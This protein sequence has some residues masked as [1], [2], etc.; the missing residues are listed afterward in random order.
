MRTWLSKKF[1]RCVKSVK[2]SVRTR[3]NSNKES[4]AIAICTTSVLHPRGRT[5]KKYSRKRLVTQKKKPRG[6]AAT[7][8][9]DDT[10][11]WSKYWE[12]LRSLSGRNDITLDVRRIAQEIES[13]VD[14]TYSV[15]YRTDVDNIFIFAIRKDSRELIHALYA[16][17]YSKEQMLFNIDILMRT[18][19]TSARQASAIAALSS[20]RGFVANLS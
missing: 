10:N 17:G 11:D 1:T 16:K 20:I 5:L 4:A 6:G 13:N 8:M 12:E 2:K 3:K 7:T 18:P 9:I 14:L 19:S 15:M